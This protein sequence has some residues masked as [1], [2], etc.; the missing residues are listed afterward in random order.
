MSE[1]PRYARDHDHYEWRPIVDRDRLRWPEG[2]RVALAAI[3][4]LDHLDFLPPEGSVQP[5]GQ[6]HRP[7][8]EYWAFTHRQ[9]GLRVGVFRVLATL[10]RHGVTPTIAIDAL[11]AIW[12][13]VVDRI[14]GEM[15]AL[16]QANDVELHINI[17]EDI[18]MEL[19]Q[20]QLWLAE[21][22]VEK[23]VAGRDLSAIDPEQE[24]E[25]CLGLD[26]A[27]TI[28]ATAR[29]I[30]ERIWSRRLEERWKPKSA[31]AIEREANP[32][33]AK[34]AVK[35]V[36]KN[37]FIPRWFIRDHW[38]TDGK[39]LRWRRTPDGWTS[40]KC[41]FGEWGYRHKLYSDPLEAYFRYCQVFHGLMA[42]PNE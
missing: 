11:T 6:F 39:V 4:I 27:D 1:A 30:H 21:Q 15:M 26:G 36:G 10:A 12:D 8:P 17:R 14:I 5:P 37:H 20:L 25:E 33:R 9:Y 2:A 18:V 13:E 28:S 35:P 29:I 38:A 40:S 7:L 42:T 32:P 24:K 16:H 3:V 22:V 23:R 31:K 19:V 41:G 34:L